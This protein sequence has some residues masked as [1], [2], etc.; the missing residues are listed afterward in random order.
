MKKVHRILPGLSIWLGLLFLSGC[1][2]IVEV[3]GT[4]PIP[5]VRQVPASVGVYYDENFKDFQHTESIEAEGTWKINLGDQNYTFFQNVLSSMFG[6]VTVLDSPQP[7][8]EQAANLDA[9]VVPKIEK[10]G[11][12][13]PGLSGLKYFSA[14]IH[15]RVTMT[16]E[17][18]NEL[19]DWKNVGYGKSEGGAFS[20]DTALGEAT[21]DAIRDGG[22]L[23]AIE[24]PKLTK[25][26]DWAQRHTEISDED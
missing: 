12:L 16:D 10:Y 23:F 5:K 7:T 25:V 13:T 18:G 4:N 9:I 14:S 26:A 1:T 3:D 20:A 24:F 15:Y 17:Q 11:F 8:P 21:M 22:A 2:T 19:A 6:Q